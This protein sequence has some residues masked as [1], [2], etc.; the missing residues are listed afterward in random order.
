M[1]NQNE[2]I[3]SIL[4]IKNP[5]LRLSEVLN[6]LMDEIDIDGVQLSKN[7]GVPVTT[8]N[9]LR[10]GDPSNNP[11]LT[12]LVPLA[13]FFSISV[14]QLIGDEL[15][16]TKRVLGEHTPNPNNWKPIPHISWAQAGKL[17]QTNFDFN[18]SIPKWSAT[19]LEVSDKAF[20]ITMEGDSMYPRFPEGTLFIIEPEQKITNRDFILLLPN[21]SVTPLFKQILIDG[22]DYYI[23]SLSKDF[24]EIKKIS[25]NVDHK[26][27]GVMVQ[28]RMEYR[29]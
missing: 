5:A 19:D 9:R 25:L 20:A 18:A 29:K 8:I 24:K 2:K 4:T 12:T 11:T 10:K 6:H 17:L 16:P 15:L 28:A 22:S 7:T 13:D 21:D 23:K 27:I 26:I 3:T 14:S 1:K